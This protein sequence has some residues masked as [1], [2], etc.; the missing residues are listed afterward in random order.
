[1]I[2]FKLDENVPVD[3]QKCIEKKGFSASSVYSEKISGIKDSSLLALC[4]KEQYVLV[5]LDIDFANITPRTLSHYPGII[6]LRAKSQGASAAITLF[7]NFL[8]KF[9]VNKMLGATLILEPEHIRIRKVEKH[10]EDG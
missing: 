3:L 6:I 10:E 2:H 8:E 9:D 5:T 1:M 4:L 7:T